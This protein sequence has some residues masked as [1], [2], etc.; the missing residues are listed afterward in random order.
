MNMCKGLKQIIIET[1]STLRNLIAKLHNCT[2]NK[3]AENS[4]LEKQVND[5]EAE[6]ERSRTSKKPGAP[7]ILGKYLPPGTYGMTIA[8]PGDRDGKHN[9]AS[10]AAGRV[11]PPVGGTRLYS[12][13]LNGGTT[14]QRFQMTV[15]SIVSRSTDKI[16]ELL[17]P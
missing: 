16:T 3:I 4:E 17:K 7:S 9:P 8:P 1:V 10:T 11:A 13:A 12:E 15:K 2:D 14:I 6:L 5:L